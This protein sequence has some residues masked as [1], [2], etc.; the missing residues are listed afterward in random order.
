MQQQHSF[1]EWL[2]S[3]SGCPSFL[4]V[5]GG[6]VPGGC[7]WRNAPHKLDIKLWTSTYQYL[8]FGSAYFKFH[9]TFSDLISW[10]IQSVEDHVKQNNFFW[11]DFRRNRKSVHHA[12]HIWGRYTKQAYQHIEHLYWALMPARQHA[13]WLCPRGDSHA[14]KGVR[15]LSLPRA[16]VSLAIWQI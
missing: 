7:M 4:Y 10:T 11:L 6:M 9:L 15:G 3:R 5:T 13:I 12:Y 8:Y 14:Q 16:W 1:G 2:L